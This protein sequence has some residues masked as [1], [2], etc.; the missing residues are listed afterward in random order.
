MMM[1]MA[2]A[3]ENADVRQQSKELL[4]KLEADPVINGLMEAAETIEDM[5]EIAK[6]YVTMKLEDFRQLFEEAMDYYKGTKVELDD[7]TM[8]YVVG[9][10]WKSFWNTFK[11]VALTAVIVA[12]VGLLCAVTAGAAAAGVAAVAAVATGTAVG[13]AAATGAVTGAI[14]GA[15][16]GVYATAKEAV[17]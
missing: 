11:K 6:R 4:A 16:A 2:M 8:E 12:G 5:Y 9:G 13:T 7:D 14:G 15:V 1:N 10:S 17:K 3:M